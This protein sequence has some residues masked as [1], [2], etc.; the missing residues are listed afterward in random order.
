MCLWVH[1]EYLLLIMANRVLLGNRTTGGYGLY[2]SE[3]GNNVLD[4]AKANLSF[5]TDSD[6]TGTTFVSKGIHQTVPFSG[7]TGTTAPTTLATVTLSSGATSSQSHA[8][9]G[10]DTFVLSS[11][12]DTDATASG[13]SF[14]KGAFSSSLSGTGFTLNSEGT[15]ATFTVA[16]FKKLSS[17]GL[18]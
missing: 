4:C 12:A 6:E 13:S 1:D 11:R 5:W 16:V 17:S 15:G 8:N 9:L 18:Y 2:I 10:A 14:S 3:P 7:G